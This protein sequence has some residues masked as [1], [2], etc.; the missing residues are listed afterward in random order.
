MERPYLGGTDMAAIL[1]LSK[2]GGPFSVWSRFWGEPEDISDRW[3]IQRGKALETGILDLYQIK[4]G[5][6]V[7]RVRKGRTLVCSE[8]GREFLRGAP[9]AFANEVGTKIVVDAKTM[10]PFVAARLADDEAP[11]EYWCQMQHYMGLSKTIFA[12]LAILS[13]VDDV[14]VIRVPI[15]SK[16]IADMWDAAADFWHTYVVT[17]KEPPP[18]GST[19]YSDA[20]RRS[21]KVGTKEPVQLSPAA[22][23][24]VNEFQRIDLE[25]DALS[26]AKKKCA[27]FV[28]AE[29]RDMGG[30]QRGMAGA[31]RVYWTVVEKKDRVQWEPLAKQLLAMVP[32]SVADEAIKKHTKLADVD[33][34]SR[35]FEIK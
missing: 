35:R 12:D 13:T 16:A 5:N 34:V 24:Y 17:G 25:I 21:A 9:D 6:R 11:V 14:R 29:L 2:Y 30:A 4:T 23:Y 22:E 1:G 32:L 10:S 18:D 26:I 7:T 31:N 3:P 27:Q 20:V 15:D 19:Q 28:Q 8:D 33:E